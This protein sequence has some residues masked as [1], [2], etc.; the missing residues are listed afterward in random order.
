MKKPK[1]V[2]KARTMP[3]TDPTATEIARERRVTEAK[4]EASITER[5][6]DNGDPKQV[7]LLAEVQ[8]YLRENGSRHRVMPNLTLQANVTHL[9]TMRDEMRMHLEILKL[10][11][12]RIT[13]S[14]LYMK[15]QAQKSKTR[16]K[17]TK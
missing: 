14:K 1:K 15:L 17:T 8:A 10:A 5:Y 16:R 12:G 4:R 6:R 13:G 2:G 7:K 9:V 11:I 3:K